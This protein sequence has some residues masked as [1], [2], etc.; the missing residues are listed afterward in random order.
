MTN[1]I[2]VS[3]TLPT[4]QLFQV[5]SIVLHFPT[6]LN[7]AV[8]EFRALEDGIVRLSAKTRR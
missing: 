1:P 5:E 8:P 6:M 3:R 7:E 4:G 2:I